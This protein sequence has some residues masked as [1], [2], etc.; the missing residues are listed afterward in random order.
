M[1]DQKLEAGAHF[2]AEAGLNLFAIL[3][4]ATLPAETSKA[5]LIADIPL[6]DYRRLVLI[7]RKEANWRRRPS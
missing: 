4:C 7:G 5:M 6:A 1:N 2:L 3:D